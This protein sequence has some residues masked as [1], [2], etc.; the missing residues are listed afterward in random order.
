[1]TDVSSSETTQKSIAR[2]CALTLGVF[3]VYGMDGLGVPYGLQATVLTLLV[4]GSLFLSQRAD[5]KLSVSDYPL[6]IGA[7]IL[8]ISFAVTTNALTLSV[9]FLSVFTAI[10][11]LHIKLA[12]GIR[13]TTGAQFMWESIH[14]AGTSF[15]QLI[16][17]N[18]FFNI[19]SCHR[20]T[21]V[22]IRGKY[23]KAL[24]LAIPLLLLFHL[25]FASVNSE[26]S[27]FA[28][29]ILSAIGEIIRFFLNIEFLWD[30]FR[31]FAYAY[32]T[33]AL[34]IL[35]FE[36][37]TGRVGDWGLKE[38]VHMV[39]GALV[40]LFLIFSA[41]QSK[42]LFISPGSMPFKALSL[43][44]QNGFWELLIA[45]VMLLSPL[46]AELRTCRTLGARRQEG[47]LYNLLK[48]SPPLHHADL[49]PR[50]VHR[51]YRAR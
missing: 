17:R 44:T 41:F 23:I 22:E 21:K 33:Y 13:P 29:A 32:L 12:S 35:R 2:L 16:S 48:S 38:S 15:G 36:P 30:L 34:L 7:V 43:Y 14:L 20:I 9:A 10:L 4:L 51:Y 37:L 31:I 18:N 42:L 39:L 47:S 6:Y 26:Y 3:I 25:L 49:H 19:R 1:M 28:D 50:I 27:S 5:K 40:I 8:G 24:L 45:A 46:R 11:L